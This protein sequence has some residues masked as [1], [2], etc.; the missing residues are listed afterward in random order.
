MFEMDF[1]KITRQHFDIFQTIP[2]QKVEGV[3]EILKNMPKNGRV[4][5]LGAGRMGYSLQSFIMRLSHIGF[6]AYMIGD[7]TLPRVGI[8]DIVVVNSSSGN[9]PS[10]NLYAK[11]AKDAGAKIVLLTSAKNC[12]IGNL[13]NFII[14]YTVKK[15]MQLM[16]T[17]HEQF[18]LLFLDYIAHRLVV[19]ND[20]NVNEIENNHS[21]LE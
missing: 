11:Q 9:T 2:H 13:S 18:S 20:L 4:I 6:E 14:L 15:N 21:I 16:K 5:G 19:D 12:L 17:V 8:G 1:E 3:V 7:T 10:I